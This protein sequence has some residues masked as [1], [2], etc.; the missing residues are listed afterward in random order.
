MRPSPEPRDPCGTR[1]SPWLSQRV[2]LALAIAAAALPVACQEKPPAPQ[3]VIWN[4]DRKADG[5]KGWAN[6]D[7]PPECKADMALADGKGFSGSRGLH[8]QGAGK[9]Y[10]GAGW[11]WFGWWPDNAGKDL[12]PYNMLQFE[13][14]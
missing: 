12:S 6:C 4:G 8:F 10:L 5:G 14:R 2:S 7:T 13:V 1:S 9:G 3:E 11:N